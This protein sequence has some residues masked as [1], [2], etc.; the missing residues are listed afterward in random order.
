MHSKR[1]TYV[2]PEVVLGCRPFQSSCLILSPFSPLYSQTQDLWHKLLHK[3]FFTN[4]N[5]MFTSCHSTV[6][7]ATQ[8]EVQHTH[9]QVE[10]KPEESGGSRDNSPP[11]PIWETVEIIPS[12]IEILGPQSS[13]SPDDPLNWP[14]WKKHAVLLALIPG[15]L[16][17]DW[18]LTWGTTVFQLQAPE[19]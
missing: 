5:D 15:C 3:H 19:W 7:A 12:T 8:T 14:W 6:D 2:G 18:T 13:V 10:G 4:F 11:L 16:L 17:T 1:G 9:E